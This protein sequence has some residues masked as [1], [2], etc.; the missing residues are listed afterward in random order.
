[1]GTVSSDD[2]LSSLESITRM[3]RSGLL[4]KYPHECTAHRMQEGRDH[5]YL[6]PRSGG[7]NIAQGGGRWGGTLGRT[8]TTGR[9]L[10]GRQ[11]HPRHPFSPRHHESRGFI[12]GESPRFFRP[13]FVPTLSPGARTRRR[14]LSIP[15]LK[16][17]IS[18]A[19]GTRSK[20]RVFARPG[21]Q[22]PLLTD[23]IFNH[24]S[25]AASRRGPPRTARPS[26]SPDRSGAPGGP[27][28]LATNP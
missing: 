18:P 15:S 23:E 22:K 7:G 16:L 13:R 24:P 8:P 25:R 27:T 5:E 12:E 14:Y 4:R 21:D 20:N 1:M 2:R 11:E 9:A 19:R 28:N 17:Q 3:P 26:F 10:K 6:E